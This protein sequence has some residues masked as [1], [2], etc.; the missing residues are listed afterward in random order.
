[1]SLGSNLVPP[2]KSPWIPFL[3]HSFL[4]S[5]M[6][7]SV[8]MNGGV[9]YSSTQREV[10]AGEK[11]MSAVMAILEQCVHCSM[12]ETGGG[13]G[14]RKSDGVGCFFEF[15]MI[16]GLCFCVTWKAEKELPRRL[17]AKTWKDM[18]WLLGQGQSRDG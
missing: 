1:M 7:I 18:I 17:P 4:L 5:G 13:S 14:E 10:G 6:G 16:F 9:Q 15:F 3:S 12:V 2:N 8:R 11:A